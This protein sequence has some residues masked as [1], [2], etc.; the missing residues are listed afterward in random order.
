[1]RFFYLAL[2]C[3][4]FFACDKPAAVPPPATTTTVA[5]AAPTAVPTPTPAA[6]DA[7]AGSSGAGRIPDG[8]SAPGLDLIS[9]IGTWSFDRS[10]ASDDG[11]MLSADG[12]ASL[13]AGSG[14][15]ALDAGNRLVIIIRQQEMGTNPDPKAERHVL[16]FNPAK[17]AGDDL[18][19]V[20]LPSKLGQPPREINAKRCPE[21]K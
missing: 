1:M 20:F 5:A 3:A 14:L 10:C 11:M 18:V 15:W 2:I 13:D 17:P 6:G 16:V 4:T 7:F 19:G 21:T 8:A 12:T 9:V